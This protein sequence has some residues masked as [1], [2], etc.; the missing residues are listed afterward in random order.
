GMGLYE[1]LEAVIRAFSLNNSPDPYVIFFLDVAFDF[2]KNRRYDPEDFTAFWK[3][4]SH[5]YSIV[6]PEGMDAVNIMTIHKAKGLEF[7]A[8]IYPFANSKVDV[9]RDQKWVQ[10]DDPAFPDFGIALLPMNKSLEKTVL[11]PI[12]TEELEKAKLDLLNI[13]YVATTRPTE[14]LFLICDMPSEKSISVNI[15]SI[16]KAFLEKQERWEDGT[17]EYVFGEQAPIAREDRAAGNPMHLGMFISGNWKKNIQLS[18]HA[19]EYWDMEDEGRNREWGN[20]VHKVLSGVLTVD[21]LENVIGNEILQG[22]ISGE[23]GNK[24]MGMLIEM[25][26]QPEISPF[27]DGRYEIKNEAGI[28]KAAGGEYRPDRL[29]FRDKKA[30]VLDYKTGKEDAKHIRQL[31]QYGQLLYDMGYLNVEKYL[32]YMDKEFTLMKV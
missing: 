30:I 25:L 29:M 24:L 12:Y 15:P 8:V 17:F 10:L 28:L 3:E 13:L 9:G 11:E 7:P 22:N 6:V 21:D 27:F 1:K 32:L 4:N 20:L 16:L 26:K 31:E 19:A 18:G 5:K 14:R 2:E 23:K